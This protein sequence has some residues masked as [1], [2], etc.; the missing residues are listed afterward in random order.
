MKNKYFA[1]VLLA[2][3]LTVSCNKENIEVSPLE[4]V[5]I[6]ATLDAGNATKTYLDGVQVKWEAGDQFQLWYG[7]LGTAMKG[8]PYVVKT[9]DALDS[10]QATFNGLG[11]ASD[12]YLGVCPLSASVDCSKKGKLTV[13]LPTAQT[14]VAGSFGSGANV[15]VAYSSTTDLSFQNVGG[16][17]AFKVSDDGGHAVKSVRL[18]GT[19][20]LSGEVEIK[21]ATL[22][23]VDAI[24]AGVNYLTLSIPDMSGLRI[25]GSN[26]GFGTD[27]GSWA[28]EDPEPGSDPVP[29][30]GG[31]SGGT[32]DDLFYFVAL[33]GSHTAFTLT[34]V[35]DAGNTAVASS[36]HAFT[37]ERNSNTLI[38]DL[39]VPS[40]KWHADATVYINEVSDTQIELYNP[41]GSTVDLSGWV[42]QSG[43]GS[44]AMLPGTSIAAGGFLTVTAGQATC[45]TGPM[46]AI[47][48]SVSL[49]N[50]GTVD[51][52]ELEVFGSGESYGR[53]TDG[54][55]EWTVFSTGSIG[56]T[57][58][59]GTVKTTDTDVV[60]LNEIDANAKTIELYNAGESSVTLTGWTLYKDG[61]VDPIWAG[62]TETIAAGEYLL[63]T[64]ANSPGVGVFTGGI[65]PKKSLKVELKNASGV[66]KDVFMRGEEGSGWGDITL[67]SNASA[68]FSRVPDGTGDWKYAVPTPGAANGE[69]TGTIEQYPAANGVVVLN[70]I[71][72]NDKFIELYS[73]ATDY[74]ISL[75]DMTIQ[76]DGNVVWTGAPGYFI[77]PGGYVLL[78]STDVTKPGKVHE[79]YDAGL[80]FD[81]GL[82]AK[83]AVRVQL[84]DNA[85]VSLDDFNYVTYSGTPAP[86]SYG[87]NADGVWYYQDATPGAA[88]TD[89]TAAV[90][91]LE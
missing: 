28:G 51:S 78:Y 47:G 9:I 14:G 79:G 86:A 13:V 29:G 6:N 24:T 8:A 42:L 69:K 45:A 73:T 4:Y 88:N 66:S 22:P 15:A 41:G 11:L 37:I 44:W 10:R 82:S 80:Q 43:E 19:D 57:N 84:F 72:G 89:G 27:G 49:V 56:E 87:R 62:S 40:A 17:L 68:S 65:S 26:E 20:A 85:G 2:G 18:V 34:L 63:L 59:N 50:G 52:V 90:T 74:K 12:D 83:K 71:N 7:A 36:T 54:G 33:P 1:F 60:V 21:Q 67:P 48:G 16:L 64:K 32:S 46:F 25:N 61:G 3:L 23:E 53:T 31:G 39:T 77:E 55:G 30:P 5:T 81:S 75:E 91:G 58:A 38:A 70:E 76:K 35:D